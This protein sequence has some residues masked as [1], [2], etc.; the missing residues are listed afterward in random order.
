MS[1]L[2]KK[3]GENRIEDNG[4]ERREKGIVWQ[5]EKGNEEIIIK[6]EKLEKKRNE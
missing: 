5:R 6:I 4:K 2:Q 1:N 3:A